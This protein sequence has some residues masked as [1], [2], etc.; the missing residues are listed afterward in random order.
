M[1]SERSGL[2][3]GT[4]RVAIHHR[5]ESSLKTHHGA[6]HKVLALG[7][8]EAE[9]VLVG[10]AVLLSVVDRINVRITNAWDAHLRRQARLCLLLRRLQARRLRP[11]HQHQ[12]A[13][14]YQTATR[15]GSCQ[16]LTKLVTTTTLNPFLQ[17]FLAVLLF[18]R[19]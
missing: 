10:V 19:Q 5:P 18:E 1:G 14:L 7:R 16:E 12:P 13:L 2:D 6:E 11:P 17:P 9:V 15:A 3:V 4:S 8:E